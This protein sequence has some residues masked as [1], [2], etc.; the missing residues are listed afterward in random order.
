MTGFVGS[1]RPHDE[2]LSDIDPEEVGVNEFEP[3][4]DFVRD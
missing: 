1:L 4:F 3:F 2:L